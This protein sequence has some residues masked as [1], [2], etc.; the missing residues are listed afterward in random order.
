M[1][2]NGI[3]FAGVIAYGFVTYVN[4]GWQYVQAF[5]CVICFVMF[6]FAPLIPESPKWLISHKND[7]KSAREVLLTL[8]SES[9]DI[10]AEV[11]ELKCMCV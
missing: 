2:T 5:P 10:D 11:C 3:F 9:D 7:Y 8:R 1:V 4:N 6:L